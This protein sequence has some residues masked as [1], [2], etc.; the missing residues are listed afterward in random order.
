MHVHNYI[1]MTK[2]KILLFLTIKYLSI[3]VLII[4]IYSRTSLNGPPKGL[5]KSGPISEVVPYVISWSLYAKRNW[6]NV[7]V[8]VA[9]WNVSRKKY[10]NC[11]RVAYA[12]NAE[13][14][15]M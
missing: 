11:S 10:M 15:Q 6:S 5:S 1:T 14:I 12:L 4:C 8:F 13:D 2:K 9:L 3:Y 7:N